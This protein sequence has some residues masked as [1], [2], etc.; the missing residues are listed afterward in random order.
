MVNEVPVADINTTPLIDVML[1]LL[2]MLIITIP[3]QLHAVKLNL[4]QGTP[5]PSVIKPEVLRIDINADNQV[6]WN[7]EVVS[8][9]AELVQRMRAAAT[10]ITQPEVHLRPDQ[11]APYAT[12]TLVLANAQRQGL[13]KIG[14]VGSEQFIP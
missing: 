11:H 7:T 14:I 6:L 1:V 4:P 8:D 9:T 10:Q 12:V 13:T 2:I 3:V 5:P